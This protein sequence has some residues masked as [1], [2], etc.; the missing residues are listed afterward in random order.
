MRKIMIAAALG[1]VFIFGVSLAKST[2]DEMMSGSG[3]TSRLLG[4]TVKNPQGKDLGTIVDIM[5]GP[6]AVFPSPFSPIGYLMIRKSGLRFPLAHCLVRNKTVPLMQIKIHWTLHPLLFLKATWLNRDC[7]K[8]STDTLACNHTGQRR[9]QGNDG[10]LSQ[11][12]C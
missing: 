7:L 11:E 5:T 3:E 9:N 4:A 8:T 10:W 12:S 6:K 2:G 1:L